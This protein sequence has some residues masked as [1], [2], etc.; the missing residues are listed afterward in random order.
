MRALLA[1]TNKKVREKLRFRSVSYSDFVDPSG[2]LSNH[3]ALDISEVLKSEKVL[4]YF[5]SG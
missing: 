4:F 3:L 1:T 5:V 2:L